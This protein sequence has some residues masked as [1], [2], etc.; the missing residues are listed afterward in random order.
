MMSPS[1]YDAEYLYLFV[2]FQIYYSKRC[3]ISCMYV[4]IIPPQLRGMQFPDKT[5]A[6]KGGSTILSMEKSSHGICSVISMASLFMQTQS[7]IATENYVPC[8][9]KWQIMFS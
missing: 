5:A 2:T 8:A 1:I 7:H 3:F 9:N 6:K 4:I